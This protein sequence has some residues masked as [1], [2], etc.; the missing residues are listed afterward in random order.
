MN[1]CIEASSPFHATPTTVILSAHCL[2]A[3]STEAAAALH[4]LQPG[5]QNQKATGLPMNEAA[6][7]WPPPTVGEVK[8][9][10]LDGEVATVVGSAVVIFAELPHAVS[11]AAAA[12]KA[13]VRIAR[14]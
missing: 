14:R 3:A 10:R 12:I 1:A 8:A 2:L 6:S 9:N 7:I 4:A 11:A 5:A 13:T